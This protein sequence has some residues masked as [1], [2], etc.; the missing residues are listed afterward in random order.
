MMATALAQAGVSAAAVKVGAAQGAEERVQAS[1]VG[2]GSA[3]EEMVQVVMAME[4][5]ATAPLE[6]VG[7]AAVE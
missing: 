2:E 6:G 3:E 5:M 4:A 1:R 7:K